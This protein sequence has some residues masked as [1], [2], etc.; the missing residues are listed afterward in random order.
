MEAIGGGE[1]KAENLGCRYERRKDWIFRDLSFSVKPGDA[2]AVV[3]PSGSGKTTLAYCL[4]GI[5]PN[6]IKAEVEG[7][8]LVDGKNV[9]ASRLRD[10][11]KLVNIVLQNYEMQIFGLTVEEDLAFSLENLG[12]E[13]HEIEA[14]VKWALEKFRLSSYRSYYVHELSGGL[15]QRLAIASSIMMAPKYLVMDEP[16]ANLDWNGIVELSKTIS[17][18]KMDGRG[19][20]IMTRRLKGLENVIDKVISLDG[21]NVSARTAAKLPEPENIV[22]PGRSEPVITFE[23]VWFRY[24]GERNYVLREINLKILKGQCVALMGPN[25]SGKTT[26][27]KHVNGLLK[28]VKGKVTILGK[29]TKEYSAAQ[30]SRYVGMVFQDPDKHITCETIWEEATFGAR[31]IGVS[32]NYAEEALKAL[33]LIDRRDDPPYLLSM[34]EKIRLSMAGAIGMNPEILI[35][36]EPT[37]GQDE[38]T[39][40]TISSMINYLRSVGKTVIIV[41]HDSDF[42]LSVSDRLVVMKDGAI[43]ADGAPK[44]ILLNRPIVEEL[45]LEP[46][47]DI[48]QVVEVEL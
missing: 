37:T 31:N 21:R 4:A 34:G 25:G 5:I 20:I 12:L 33:G 30:L 47:T 18:L 7:K 16:T 24:S 9:L 19:V 13:E 44:E 41:T 32:E 6:R 15:K 36:D 48:L 22:N 28:P 26:L 35:L 40:M 39:L 1:L 14:R 46:P 38:E 45:G 17:A 2:V 43:A 11:V 29:D 8:I 42:A 3:G 27:I 10:N 23:D